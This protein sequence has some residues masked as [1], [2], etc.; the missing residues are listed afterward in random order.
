MLGVTTTQG[1]VLQGHRF[2]KAERPTILRASNVMGTV[3]PS[4]PSS[5]SSLVKLQLSLPLL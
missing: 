2:R 3:A 5:L 1:T 4:L